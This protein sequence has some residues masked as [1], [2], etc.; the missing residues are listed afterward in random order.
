MIAP[1]ALLEL[2]TCCSILPPGLWW[3]S[4]TPLAALGLNDTVM[5]KSAVM[6][7]QELPFPDYQSPAE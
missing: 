2:A 6:L 3:L 4:L 1:L 7:G 5:L